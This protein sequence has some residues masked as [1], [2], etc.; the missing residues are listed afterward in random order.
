MDDI[1]LAIIKALDQNARLS[2]TQLS[3]LVNLSVPAVRERLYRL[4]DS[5][6][7]TGYRA[8]FDYEKLGRGISAL[9]LVQL[10][11]GSPDTNQ[12]FIDQV[13]REDDIISCATITGDF[14]YLLMIQIESLSAL[15]VLL[16]RLRLYGVL[17]SNTSFI[18]S[19][20]K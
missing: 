9:V 7:I 14:E 20:K 10:V 8:Q 12:R 13:V 1:S 6:V 16:A 5:G 19:Q 18:L 15:E 4:E 17:R 11:D 3:R 2:L